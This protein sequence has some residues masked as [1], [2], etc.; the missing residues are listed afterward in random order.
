MVKILLVDDS[1]FERGVIKNL[2]KK[3]GHNDVVEAGT[4]EEG[5]EQYKKGKP[6]LI[7]LDIR[8]PGMSGLEMLRKLQQLDPSSCNVVVISA[9][10]A[11]EAQEEAQKLGASAYVVKPV[12]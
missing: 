1:A 2:L 9:V 7:L 6:N 3:L 12:T 8:M 4:G 10:G 11:D 5:I